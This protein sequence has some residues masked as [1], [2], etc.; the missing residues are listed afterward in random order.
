MAD[1]PSVEEWAAIMRTAGFLTEDADIIAWAV[2]ARLQRDTETKWGNSAY[3]DRRDPIRE[4]PGEDWAR[5]LVQRE[6]RAGL[7]QRQHVTFVGPWVPTEA[8]D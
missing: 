7:F 3:T 8:E 6:P 1:L 5:A 2:V 4:Q